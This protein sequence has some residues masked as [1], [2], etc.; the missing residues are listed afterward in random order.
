MSALS[1]PSCIL[2]SWSVRFKK[3]PYLA[4][5][6][7][8]PFFFH[9][10]GTEIKIRAPVGAVCAVIGSNISENT[11]IRIV[12]TT[13]TVDP[14]QRILGYIERIPLVGL[15]AAHAVCQY[16]M[17]FV[18]ASSA[19]STAYRSFLSRRYVLSAFY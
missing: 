16:L 7:A 8:H 11:P 12:S 17:S 18:H 10:T 15:L 19:L 9:F 13:D 4:L 6:T 14:S 3:K 5:F 1:Q 2:S